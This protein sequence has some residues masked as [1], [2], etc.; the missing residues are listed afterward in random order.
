MK[1][2]PSRTQCKICKANIEYDSSD[3]N[4][5]NESLRYII[6]PLCGAKI[7]PGL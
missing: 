2:L 7:Y 6:C 3:L 4:G 1:I 5:F